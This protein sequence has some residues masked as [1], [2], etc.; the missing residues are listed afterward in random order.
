M[1]YHITRATTL[2]STVG[3]SYLATFGLV[4]ASPWARA[5]PAYDPFRHTPSEA[6]HAEKKGLGE[7]MLD[8]LF[9]KILTAQGIEVFV[10]AFCELPMP[11]G[12]THIQNPAYHRHSYT[13]TDVG[14]VIALTPLVLRKFVNSDLFIKQAPLALIRKEFYL[15]IRND[16]TCH[17]AIT[18]IYLRFARCEFAV[19]DRTPNLDT[20]EWLTRECHHLYSHLTHCLFSEVEA[21]KR[22]NIPKFHVSLHYR[23]TVL[24]Y[25]S[26]PNTNSDAGERKHRSFKARAVRTN[27]RTIEK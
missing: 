14:R 5:Y 9:D 12:W 22:I 7:R 21:A 1:E 4:G 11:H 24:D 23:N 2:D 19:F 6:C 3:R 18:L 25:G 26:L 8:Y 16:M 17:E 13:Y 15:D 27:G 20:I 10:E